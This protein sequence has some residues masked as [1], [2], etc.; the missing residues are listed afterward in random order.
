VE[1]K[2]VR[3]LVF[4]ASLLFV[5]FLCAF[6]HVPPPVLLALFL[7]VGTGGALRIWFRR[8]TLDI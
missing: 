7:V 3:I 8:H 6:L 5:L 4:L 1:L 2:L